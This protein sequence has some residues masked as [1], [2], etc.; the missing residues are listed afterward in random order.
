QRRRVNAA[1]PPPRGSLTCDSVWAIFCAPRFGR[2]S[3]YTR[4]GLGFPAPVQGVNKRSSCCATEPCPR[5]FCSCPSS[6]P[7][8]IPVEVQLAALGDEA[9]VF[10]GLDG[11][12]DREEALAQ[13]VL[14]EG[15]AMQEPQRRRPV[16]GQIG[17]G[18]GIAIAL[19]G[20]PGV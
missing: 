19:D 5:F 13:I 6:R 1:V 8:Q 14:Q 11:M 16:V 18:L 9:A 15:R 3:S 17:A 10:G 2:Q 20:G 7:R 4:I 12:V